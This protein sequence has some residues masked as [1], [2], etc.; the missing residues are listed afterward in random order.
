MS[1]TIDP[2]TL[3]KDSVMANKNVELDPA[4]NQLGFES[5]FIKLPLETGTAW[6]RKDDKGY[7]SVGSLWLMLK[8]RDSRRGDYAR[9]GNKLNIPIV[10]FRDKRE[11][12]EYF[13]GVAHESAQI[14]TAMRT[15][16]LI[17]K[18]DIR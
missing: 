1:E 13:T 5:S 8:M 7:Y 3:L 2:I 14:D 10:D 16:T 12:Q 15:Q 17:R 18:T 6:K 11:I 9:E 4:T